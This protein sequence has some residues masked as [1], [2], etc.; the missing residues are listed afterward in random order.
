MQTGSSEHASSIT[1]EQ[2]EELPV[3][4]RTVTTLIAIA[5]G[6]VDAAAQGARN[7]GEPAQRTSASP[8][9]VPRRII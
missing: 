3:Y 2:T 1:A 9:T 8:A 7:L 4:G 5:P 6:V